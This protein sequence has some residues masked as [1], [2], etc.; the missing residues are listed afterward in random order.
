MDTREK[1]QAERDEL[2][3]R[4]ATQKRTIAHLKD[5][6]RDLR[7][8]RDELRGLTASLE[9]ELVEARAEVEALKVALRALLAEPDD[10]GIALSPPCK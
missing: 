8:E 6:G 3:E 9:A 4:V 2:R 1:L 5:G 7:N 10:G